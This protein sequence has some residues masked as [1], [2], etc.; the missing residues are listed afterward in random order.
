[1]DPGSPQQSWDVR[2]DAL[3]GNVRHL[4]TFLSHILRI[5]EQK[6]NVNT[7]IS[8]T[9]K[10]IRYVYLECKAKKLHYFLYVLYEI[11]EGCT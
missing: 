9:Q 1:M 8:T 11:E 2:D 4:S 5:P 6:P 3:Q 10:S 7:K